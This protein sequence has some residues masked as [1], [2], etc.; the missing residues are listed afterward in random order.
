[1]S[2]GAYQRGDVIRWRDADGTIR[3]G[4]FR[5]WGASGRVSIGVTKAESSAG[6]WVGE[7]QIVEPEPKRGVERGT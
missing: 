4:V 7:E 6:W 2:R 5:R 3:Q 1:V